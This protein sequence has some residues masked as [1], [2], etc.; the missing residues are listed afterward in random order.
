ME[1]VTGHDDLVAGWVGHRIQSL[2]VPPYVTIGFARNGVLCGGVVF[3]CWNGASMFISLASERGFTRENIK[4]VY[5]YAFEQVGA[6]RLTAISRRDNKRMHAIFPRLGF[7]G[8][9]AVLKRF[10]GH[11]KADDAFV[12]GLYPENARK[13]WDRAIRLPLHQTR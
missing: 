10:F 1:V 2:I 5:Q 6:T 13:L 12:F 11:R 8:P 7:V 9:E 3:T 4:T